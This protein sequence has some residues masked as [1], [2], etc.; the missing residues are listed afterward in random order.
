MAPVAPAAP[1]VCSKNAEFAVIY[2][3]FAFV[4]SPKRAWHPIARVEGG[5][6]PQ[7]SN[8]QLP[9]GPC[10]HDNRH[11]GLEKSKSQISSSQKAPA[12]TTTGTNGLRNSKSQVFSSQKAAAGT[13]PG[14]TGLKK[15]KS[16]ISSSQKAP[17][18]MASGTQDLKDTI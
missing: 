16:Q 2:N 18:G 12:G 1:A 17:A 7:K 10:G 8:F 9:K 3:T 6:E 11:K 13:T 14:T 5:S 4:R 15:S